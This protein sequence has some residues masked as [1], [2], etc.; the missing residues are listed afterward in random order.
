M[1]WVWGSFPVQLM[2][3]TQLTAAGLEPVLAEEEEEEE[4]PYTVA[5]RLNLEID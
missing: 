2:H 4:E 1:H 5:G 3:S